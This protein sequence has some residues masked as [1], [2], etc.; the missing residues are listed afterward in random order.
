M[1]YVRIALL[2][3]LLSCLGWYILLHSGTRLAV[4]MNVGLLI[5][6]SADKIEIVKARNFTG[7][8]GLDGS[9]VS[10]NIPRH[11]FDTFLK[12]Q[13]WYDHPRRSG[14]FIPFPDSLRGKHP[15]AGAELK[16]P[17]G[18]MLLLYTDTIGENTLQVRISID[19][20]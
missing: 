12:Q 13:L 17:V 7:F 3:F 10:F 6:S 9:V 18:D 20:N 16:A 19:F 5:P 2:V 4:Y 8:D 14:V 15:I 11:D 1:R